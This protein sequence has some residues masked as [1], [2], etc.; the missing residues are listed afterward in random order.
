MTLYSLSKKESTNAQTNELETNQNTDEEAAANEKPFEQLQSH[1]SR[2]IAG[3]LIFGTQ[4]EKSQN[5]LNETNINEDSSHIQL[6][7]N[8]RGEMDMSRMSF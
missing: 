1:N 2:N 7:H 4:N 6:K 8:N 5:A 3:N